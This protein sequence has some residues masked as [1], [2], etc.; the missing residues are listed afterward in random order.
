MMNDA[1]LR[2]L[3]QQHFSVE[4]LDRNPELLQKVLGMLRAWLE[5]EGKVAYPTR[6][7]A[8]LAHDFSDYSMPADGMAFDAFLDELH[9]TVLANS[10]QLNH[11]MY[12]G[13]MTQALPWMSV[14]AEAFAAAINQNQVKIETAFASTL[15]E[16]QVL[17]WMHRK[18]YR[19]PDA[20]YADAM[21]ATS[22][23]IGNVVSG[24][25][26]GNLTALA[27]ALEARLPGTRKHGLYATLEKSGYRGV[28]VVGSTRAHYSLKKAVATLGLGESA[29][30]A[31][32]VD[33]DGRIDLRALHAKLDELKR[34]RILVLALIGIAGATET[35]AIDPLQELAE[36]ARQE[37]AWFH[38]DAA[39]GG[40]LLLAERFRPLFEGIE[41]ADSVVVDGHKL[42]W[43]P[44]AQGMVLFKDRASLDCLRHNSNYIIRT[45]SGDLGQTSLEGSR[46]FDALKLW[47]SLK[48]LG[49]SGYALLLEHAAGLT[50]AMRTLLEDEQDF[51]LVTRSDTFIL[52]YRFAPKAL[53]MAMRDLFENGMRSDA[54]ALNGRLNSL[55]ARLQETQKS[56]G[57]SFVSRTVLESPAFANG[58]TVLRVVLSNVATTP[59]HL[60]AILA[61]QR[62]IGNTLLP[63]CGLSDL[64]YF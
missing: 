33:R 40:A 11:P 52:T 20:Y 23:A 27:V 57:K 48:V 43:V 6:P 14:V 8:A 5:P 35:G 54:A 56:S 7:F 26:V 60:R 36:T 37:N 19:Y 4:A 34:D 1:S 45:E 41:S 28:A 10:A 15:V 21:Q 47:T 3:A 39:W 29:M 30:H 18:V 46:R 25:T 17:G 63:E 16:K 58:V 49:E 55:N 2:S 22:Q 42:F 59:D 13:H 53:R 44:M 62:E 31:V 32:A 38:V 64:R 51:E 9:G 24:G 12:I 61:E 50:A